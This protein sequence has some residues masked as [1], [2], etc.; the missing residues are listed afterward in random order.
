M[1]ADV[2]TL[3]SE[4]TTWR[5]SISRNIIFYGGLNGQ[6]GNSILYNT[7]NMKQGAL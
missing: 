7:I 5:R 3:M 2:V 4:R 6:H 1:V